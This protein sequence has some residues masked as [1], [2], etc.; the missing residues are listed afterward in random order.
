M[1][2]TGTD[3]AR[4]AADM[5]LTNDDFST[6]AFAVQSGRRMYDNLRKGVRYYL[7]VKLG[8][9]SIFLLP[10][11]LG[12]PLPFAP[13]QIIVLEL[14]M[15]LGASAAFVAEPGEKDLMTQPP[16]NPNQRFM[17]RPM[18][19]TI[20]LGAIS[21]FLAVSTVYL[22]T[23]FTTGNTLVAQSSAFAAWMFGHIFLAF[24]MRSDRQPLSS[25]GLFSN[26][27][28]D[29]WAIGAIGFLI[30]AIA[31]PFLHP[32]LKL[33]YLNAGQW[34]FAVAIAFV[35]TFWVETRKVAEKG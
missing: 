1:G 13:I 16:R 31:T 35:F 11:L 25:F 33:T 19:R 4:E 21:L 7:A 22:V 29:V 10:V 15:D 12:I 3:V 32:A 2:E 23:N 6:I 28:M 9:I 27:P 17:D 26:R 24:N 30:I 20:V 34:L 5:I 8:L 14:F 18:L